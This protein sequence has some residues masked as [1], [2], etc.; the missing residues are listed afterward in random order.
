MLAFAIDAASGRW[1]L[2]SGDWPSS[3]AWMRDVPSSGGFRV[4]WLGDPA[5]LPVDAKIVDGIGFGLTRDGPGDARTLWAAPENTASDMLAAALVAARGGDTTRLGHLVA[6]I[7]VRYIAVVNRLAPGKGAV[8]PGDPRLADALTRQLDLTI[9]RIDDG[10][11][12]YSNDAWM[13]RRAVVPADTPVTPVEP[14]PAA[15]LANAARSDAAIDAKGV[16]GSV[17][18]SDPAGPGTLLWAESAAGGWHATAAGHDLAHSRAFNWTNAY[19]LPVH[20]SVALRY[21]AGNLPGVRVIVAVLAW[22]LAL[23]IWRRTR[24]RRNRSRRVST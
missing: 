8:V 22:L 17:H 14:G 20:A 7:G 1:G 9:S 6:P 2:P 18:G 3:V 16:N 5:V 24:A 19:A 4:L 11:V 10:A 12:I 23:V 13:P 21:H 15:G